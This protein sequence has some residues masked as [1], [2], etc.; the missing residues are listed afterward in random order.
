[1]V[2]L[3]YLVI[4]FVVIWYILPILACLDEEKSGNPGRAMRFKFRQTD[5]NQLQVSGGGVLRT[6]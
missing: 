6:L 5:F 4:C 3:V 2:Y 1:L